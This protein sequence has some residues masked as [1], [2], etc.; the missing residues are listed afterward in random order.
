MKVKKT[1]KIFLT[2]LPPFPPLIKSHCT[3]VT[4]L[5]NSVFKNNWNT[6][7]NIFHLEAKH[8][9]ILCKLLKVSGNYIGMHDGKFLVVIIYSIRIYLRITAW[10]KLERSPRRHLVQPS[11]SSRTIW[12]QLPRTASWWLLSIP[13]D[14]DFTTF[15]GNLCLCCIILSVTTCLLMFRQRLLCFSLGPLPLVQP[16]K[17]DVMVCGEWSIEKLIYG[18][19]S[20]A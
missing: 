14:R 20:G 19:C 2:L 7:E 15:L 18:F 16:V 5:R 8:G 11:C 10:L 3:P 6:L 4:C 17:E 13:K 1:A 12:S 9:N